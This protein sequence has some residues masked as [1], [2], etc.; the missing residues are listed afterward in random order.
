[1][2]DLIQL[3]H[4][5][6]LERNG[7]NEQNITQ[8][9]D[10]LLN[11]K[12]DLADLYFEY[13]RQETWLL[14]DRI[15]K[16]G[17]YHIDQ[18]VG[19]RAVSGEKTGFSSTEDLTLPSLLKAAKTAS[20]I[21]H[22]NQKNYQTPITQQPR[23]PLYTTQDPLASLAEAEKIALLH[24]VDAAARACDKRVQQVTVSLAAVHDTVLICNREKPTECR[25]STLS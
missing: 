8:V 15:V 18:G 6:L 22:N 14:E 17:S 21:A 5:C 4:T 16:E 23:R 10:Q 25:Y 1:M 24:S 19:L 13:S 2:Q 12:I 20:T 9:M 3:A 11:K 7:L